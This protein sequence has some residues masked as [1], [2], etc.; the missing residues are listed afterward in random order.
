[1]DKLTNIG[2]ALVKVT[3]EQF[4]I[5]EDNFDN[6]A[7]IKLQTNF[8][9]AA[10]SKQK[11]VAVFNAFT[12]ETNGKQFLLIEAG[13][14][15]A[16]AP[17]SWDIMLDPQTNKLTVPKGFLQHMAMLT[18]GTNRGILHSKTENTCFNQYYIPTINVAELIKKD[19]IF[20]FK[21]D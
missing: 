12:F 13:C 6:E 19:T 3:T 21:E 17:E 8:R 9:F 5:I 1:M 15:F 7:E 10:D 11:L 4:A 20:E 16:I 18:V 14:H 2:F